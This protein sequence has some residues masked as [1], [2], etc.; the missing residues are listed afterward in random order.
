MAFVGAMV[1]FIVILVANVVAFSVLN[2]MTLAVIERVR[3]LGTLRSLGFTRRQVR[4]LFLREAA[5]LTAV[6]VVVGAALAVGIAELLHVVDFRFEPPGAGGEIR[7]EFMPSPAA[8][9]GTAL[10]FLALTVTATFLAVRRKARAQVAAL[11]AEVA[12]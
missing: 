4:A 9:A 3:E 11:I 1:F 5:L 6:A 12:A 7:L 8:L 2:A 10:F